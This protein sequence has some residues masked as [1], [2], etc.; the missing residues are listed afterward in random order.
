MGTIPNDPGQEAAD[1][2]YPSSSDPA[3]FTLPVNGHPLHALNILSR[4]F[5]TVWSNGV[6]PSRCRG[7]GVINFMLQ[8]S[9]YHSKFICNKNLNKGKW[10]LIYKKIKSIGL[11]LTLTVNCPSLKENE[12]Q[13]NY[14][15]RSQ[16][17]QRHHNTNWQQLINDHSPLYLAGRQ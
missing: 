14:N 8:S 2:H 17:F 3:I 1:T 7:R 11:Q 9:S 12:Y 5:S 10:Q 13:G 6:N 16:W 4:S 15:N